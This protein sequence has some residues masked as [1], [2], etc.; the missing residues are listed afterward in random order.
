[1]TREEM[2]KMS[3]KELKNHIASLAKSAQALSGQDLIDAMDEVKMAQEI[4]DEIKAREDLAKIAADAAADQAAEGQAAEEGGQVKDSA[5]AKS[6]RAL[7]DGKKVAFKAMHR[8]GGFRNAISGATAAMATHAASEIIPG[9]NN[10]SSL[11]DRVR[12]TPL[13]GG[14]SYK[15]PYVV[16]YGDNAGATA[17]GADYN[18]SEPT[19]AYA[20]IKREKITAYCE[21]PEEMQKLPDAD[22][23]SVIDDSVTRAVKRYASRMI[24]LGDGST[25]Q[26]MGI[27]ANP[28]SG[29][30]I[31]VT[32]DIPLSAIDADTLDEII[33]S[34]GGDEDTEDGA[35]LILS[36]KD[37][38]AFAKVKDKNGRKVYTIKN[39]GNVGTIDEVPY[40]INSACKDLAAASADDYCMAYGALSNYEVGV[41]SDLE[42]TKSTEYKFK[43]GMTA[44]KAV[45]FMGGN[46]V[47]KNGFVRVKKA[48]A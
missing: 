36:K 47:A 5:K 13:V 21:E 35:V 3:K 25:S 33:Y 39:N 11:I 9:F 32:T 6:G 14:E 22:Y 41:F 19:F 48:N 34:Y 43:Q 45:A 28:V 2:L 8:F 31:D 46:V 30:A 16:G 44:Y 37:L 15:R 42:A 29:G 26:F 10:V 27:F 18:T 20:E 1:M 38:K 7:K 23:D 24:L 40:I 12:V 17:E 4:M